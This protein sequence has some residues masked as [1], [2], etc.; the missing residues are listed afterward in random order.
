VQ[1]RTRISSHCPAELERAL[2]ADDPAPVAVLFVDLDR[3]KTVNDTHGHAVGDELLIVATQRLTEQARATD[4]VGRIG[5]DEFLLICPG[6]TGLEQAREIAQRVHDHVN[7]EAQLGGEP[8]MLSASVG[9]TLAP[10]GIS[11]EL[12]VAQA[13]AAMYEAKKTGSGPVLFT[14][15]S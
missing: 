2:S 10:E 13:D 3:F 12:L 5:G 14:S 15:T 11:T 7:G 8:W 4:S 1:R 9:V 6:V